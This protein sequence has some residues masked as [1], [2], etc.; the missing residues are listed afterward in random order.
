MST[1]STP[2]FN[3]SKAIQDQYILNSTKLAPPQSLEA[4]EADIK[5]MEISP[6]LTFSGMDRIANVFQKVLSE[7]SEHMSDPSDIA[8]ASQAFSS[9]AFLDKLSPTGASDQLIA[10]LGSGQ[11]N[12]PEGKLENLVRLVVNGTA[13]VFKRD[14]K[15]R[16]LEGSLA[17]QCQFQFP[18]AKTS[19]A[20]TRKIR[21]SAA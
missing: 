14:R 5:N 1:S 4:Y 13:G 17:L 9:K 11:C 12:L 16:Q 8:I 7:G 21:K 18:V 3:A 20:R 19:Y 6:F 10:W 15:K 2:S